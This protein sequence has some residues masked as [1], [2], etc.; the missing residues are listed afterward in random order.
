VAT[1]L[2]ALQFLEQALDVVGQW[3][4]DDITPEVAQTIADQLERLVSPRLHL[5]MHSLRLPGRVPMHLSRLGG[6]TALPDGSTAAL[7]P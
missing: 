4:D 7:E 1:I 3:G 5:V 2:P 6:E